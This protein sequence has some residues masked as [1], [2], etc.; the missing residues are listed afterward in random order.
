MPFLRDATSRHSSFYLRQILVF[1]TNGADA[2]QILPIGGTAMLNIDITLLVTLDALLVEGSVTGAANKL[3]LSV[4]AISRRLSHL[5]ELIHDPLFVQAGRRLA[6]TPRALELHQRVRG[7]LEDL[8]SILSQQA[9]PLEKLERTF[10][11]RTTD[12]FA[13]HWALLAERLRREAPNVSLRFHPHLEGVEALRDR[14]VDLE[15]TVLKDTGPEVFKQQL[16]NDRYVGVATTKH[17]IFKAK[18]ISPR[19]FTRYGHISA[20]RRGLTHGPI[21]HALAVL[22]LKR[23]VA[24][25]TPD[26]QSAL[27]TVSASQLIG[28]IPL[29][30]ASLARKSM[31]LRLFEL[32]V[33]TPTIEVS[34]VWH[35]RSNGDAA[36]KW[37]R[38]HVRDVFEKQRP[39]SAHDKQH[40]L[41]RF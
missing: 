12:G 24:I 39:L 3:N 8:N 21:D 11:L 30:V 20:S 29:S 41:R 31:A 33:P 5:R 16:F 18:T 17:P 35:P 2:G 38:Q 6:P 13:P 19:S 14:S 27:A 7:V 23:D 36:H 4:P 26:F 34:Q 10:N 22:G 32:P 40:D 28:A 15:I 9:T 25:V 37:L 1:R